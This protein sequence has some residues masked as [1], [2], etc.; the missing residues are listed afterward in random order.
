MKKRKTRRRAESVTI[1]ITTTQQVHAHLEAL[2]PL[3][4]HGSSV[5]EAAE[6]VLC[7][8]LRE[9]LKRTRQGLF[10]PQKG[11]NGKR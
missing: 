9:D 3:G 1:K 8:S 4:L 11:T 6:R 10:S 2:L 7:E 5:A